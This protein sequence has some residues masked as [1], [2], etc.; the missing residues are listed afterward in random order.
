MTWLSRK[1]FLCLKWQDSKQHPFEILSLVKYKFKSPEIRRQSYK[2]K[3][4]LKK[5][6][7]LRNKK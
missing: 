4:I 7:F 2:T 3:F 1:E 6:N 5:T